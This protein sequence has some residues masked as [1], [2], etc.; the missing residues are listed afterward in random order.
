MIK[1]EDWDDMDDATL[2]TIGTVT[3]F[4]RESSSEFPRQNSAAEMV[5]L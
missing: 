3:V 5:E 1:D 4:M 2:S